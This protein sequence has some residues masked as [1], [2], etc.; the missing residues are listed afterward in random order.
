MIPG[1]SGLELHEPPP[2][3]GPGNDKKRPPRTPQHEDDLR[4]RP[5]QGRPEI[6][7]D[8]EERAQQAIAMQCLNSRMPGYSGFIPSARAEYGHTAAVTGQVAVAAG[9]ARRGARQASSAAAEATLLAGAAASTASTLPPPAA[10]PDEHPLGKSRIGITRNH[11]VPTIPGYSGYIPGK[12]A[13][14]LI[15]GGITHT[16]RMAGRTIAERAPRLP[17]QPSSP[18]V[19][20]GGDRLSD[21]YQKERTAEGDARLASHLRDHCT[22]KIP[23]YTGHIP[24]VKGDTIYGA[25]S[26][27]L[28]L[29]AADLCEDQIFN[30]DGCDP[31]RSA[32]QFPG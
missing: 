2:W 6:P 11:W 10:I 24:R 20:P 28:N 3:I 25:G 17:E 18:G 27:R 26:S 5:A 22:T 4:W 32:V 23:G 8:P 21:R 29:L 31:A 19:G 1:T 12:H 13:E 16:C 14:N 30:P 9:Q 15:G 7:Q